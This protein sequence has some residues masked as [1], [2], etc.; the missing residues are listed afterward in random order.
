MSTK[1]TNEFQNKEYTIIKQSPLFKRTLKLVHTLSSLKLNPTSK[2][3]YLPHGKENVA[4]HK[5][6]SEHI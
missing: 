2:L 6:L 1:V 5:K 4:E 3:K